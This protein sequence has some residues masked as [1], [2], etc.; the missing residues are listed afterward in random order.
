[1][2]SAEYRLKAGLA[3]V[4]RK[5]VLAANL[6]PVPA[7]VSRVG[8]VGNCQV[9]GMVALADAM[10][11]QLEFVGFEFTEANMAS[12]RQQSSADQPWRGLD[13]IWAHPNEQFALWLQ[14]QPGAFRDRVRPLPTIDT[15]GFHPDCSYV[16]QGGHVVDSP[17]GPYH[18]ALVLWA[19]RQGFDVQHT[20]ALFRREVFAHLGYFDFHAAGINH[21]VS[22]GRDCAMPMAAWLARWQAGGVWMHTIN[23]PRL[24]VLA[25]VV[26]HCLGVLGIK[27]AADARAVVPDELA[28]SACWP[29]YPAVAEALGLAGEGSYHFKCQRSPALH[30]KPVKYLGLE[31]FVAQSL[32]LYARQ[33]PGALVCDRLEAEAFKTLAV[34]L[35]A[36]QTR[37]VA[38]PF[39][40]NPYSGL[41]DHHFWRRAV[42]RVEPAQLD[43]VVSSRF[44]IAPQDKVATAGS[45]FAQHVARALVAHGF[46]FLVTE[47]G[48]HLPPQDRLAHNYGVFTARF[49]NVYTA[50]QLLQLQNM[51]LGLAPQPPDLVW[52]RED[53][54]WIDG[55]RPYIEPEGFASVHDAIDSRHE[56]LACT[57][58]MLQ[59][60]DVLVFTLGLTEGWQRLTDGVVVPIA[61][62]V[63]SP[64]APM[65]DYGFLNFT[66][67]QVLADMR[68]FLRTLKAVNR[69]VRVFLTVSPVPLM[70]TFENRSVVSSTVY[71]KSVLRT[72]AGM[73]EAEFP[74]VGYFASYEVITA[75]PNASHYFGPDRRSVT[76]EGVSHVMRLFMKHCAQHPAS[77]DAT[78]PGAAMPNATRDEVERAT[79]AVSCVVCDEE[80]LDPTGR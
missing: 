12:L 37:P 39:T 78:F 64:L 30:G 71:S 33:S 62:G 16:W 28:H 54:R 18:S 73:L 22:K 11:N 4:A 3:P 69:R 25:D 36:W 20:L 63:V 6:P 77:A 74:W 67:D 65:Q 27:G 72:V 23:H 70:A 59:G 44:R 68:A 79:Q 43:P 57:S 52:Q 1:M 9:N 29:V 45:C 21:M 7:N 17:I 75:G 56:M 24:P 51:A 50:R 41:P 66:A 13:V 49:G 10:Q 80:H 76:E 2:A 34:A 53:G 46:N 5:V 61:P 42:E 38:A 35:Q 48:D 8:M 55:L 19:H 15:L 58:D 40:R 60:C 31:E 14:Q 26:Q 32:A 47:P